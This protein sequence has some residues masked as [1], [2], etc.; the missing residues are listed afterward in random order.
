MVLRLRKFEG[1]TSDSLSENVPSCESYE[2]F[3]GT[4]IRRGVESVMIA[5]IFQQGGCRR[6]VNGE[7][8]KTQF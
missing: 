5:Y 7:D 2:K 4:L 8:P 1:E 6:R 3:A